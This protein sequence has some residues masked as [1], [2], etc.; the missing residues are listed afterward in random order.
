MSDEETSPR[1]AG[2]N[3]SLASF[4]SQHHAL[5]L[6][7]RP[8]SQSTGGV[9]PT[10][11]LKKDQGSWDF[12]WKRSMRLIELEGQ[13]ERQSGQLEAVRQAH[14]ELRHRSEESEA[15][16]YGMLRDKEDEAECLRCSV[17]HLEEEGREA[18]RKLCQLRE[19]MSEKEEEIIGKRLYEEHRMESL[20]HCMICKQRE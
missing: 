20:S 5:G 7:D 18:Q 15:R 11:R 9:V 16:L 2:I 14:A 8:R 19:Q 13:V 12:S 3:A 4:A 6:E 10:M 1:T 17:D